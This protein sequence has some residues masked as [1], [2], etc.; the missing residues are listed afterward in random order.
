M[1]KL[2]KEQAREDAGRVLQ[3]YWD[4]GF[5]VDPVE[6]AHRLGIKVWTAELPHTVAGQF[7]Q[8]EGRPAG[9]YLNKNDSGTRQAFT[10]A[11][12]VGHWWE[13][14]RRGDKEYSFMDGRGEA[15]L[16]DPHGWYADCFAACLL[17]PEAKFRRKAD[18]GFGAAK[19]AD[20]FGVPQPVVLARARSLSVAI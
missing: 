2:V 10:C 15:P 20:F 9:A 4:D 17:M 1:T 13:C 12:Q 19:L 7:V 11:R 3:D 18:A 6:I 16:S 5:P 8:R 14:T